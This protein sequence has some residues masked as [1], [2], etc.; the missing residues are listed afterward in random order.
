MHFQ[1][2]KSLDSAKDVFAVSANM[3]YDEVH[4]KPREE[5]EVEYEYP[6]TLLRPSGQGTEPVASSTN[7]YRGMATSNSVAPEYAT[8]EEAVCST[9][10]SS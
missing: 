9:N 8:T 5:A 3:A 2:R 6:D 7:V 4:V 1:R 10:L